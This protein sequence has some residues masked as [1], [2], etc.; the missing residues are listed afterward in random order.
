MPQDL[1]FTI[2][3]LRRCP[4]SA[5]GVRRNEK[6]DGAVPRRAP[7]AERSERAVRRCGNSHSAPAVATIDLAEDSMEVLAQFALVGALLSAATGA[8]VL[9]WVVV[10]RWRTSE[11]DVAD[12]SA[13]R[14]ARVA[15]A[16]ALLCFAVAAGFGVIGLVQQRPASPGETT[17]VTDATEL[18]VRLRAVEQRLTSA[19]QQL[20]LRG[21]VA[22]EPGAMAQQPIAMAQQPGGWEAQ[23]AEIQNRLA[24]MEARA[25]ASA[26]P[27]PQPV[28]A[29][30]PP[31]VSRRSSPAP[32]APREARAVAA[33]P[34][35]QQPVPPMGP[36][37]VSRRSSP[38]PAASMPP[39]PPPSASVQSPELAASPS[40]STP[41]PPPPVA[42]ASPTPENVPP[43]LAAPKEEVPIGEQL[44]REWDLVKRHARTGSDELRAGWEEVKR[45][46]RP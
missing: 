15:R 29:M 16:I 40:S 8:L 46:F 31:A 13:P 14:P 27:T 12:D 19:E 42:A 26:P 18:V 17:A 9:A 10:N 37:A 2:N 45:L 20:R 7:S 5:H 4:W 30:Q 41:P 3:R 24:A 22:Q 33:V 6:E 44:R 35:T 11:E 23:L 36:P 38:A 28:P 21:A 1:A 32:A 39:P 25:V 34:P 43:R